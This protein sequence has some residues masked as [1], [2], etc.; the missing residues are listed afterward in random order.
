MEIPYKILILEDDQ[1]LN[2]QHAKLFENHG[3]LVKAVTSAEEAIA[4]LSNGDFDPDVICLDLILTEGGGSLSGYEFFNEL[5]TKW[6]SVAVIVLTAKSENPSEAFDF[7]KRGVHEYIKKSSV[8]EPKQVVAAAMEAIRAQVT[9]QQLV[10]ESTSA[11]F[12]AWQSAQAQVEREI[13]EFLLDARTFLEVDSI[14]SKPDLANAREIIQQ[15]AIAGT[16]LKKKLQAMCNLQRPIQAKRRELKDVILNALKRLQIMGFHLD[17][18]FRIDVEDSIVAIDCSAGDQLFFQ[19]FSAIAERLG[20]GTIHHCNTTAVNTMLTG[21][22]GQQITISD[23]ASSLTK[24]QTDLAVNWFSRATSS[25]TKTRGLFDFE[26][27]ASRLTQATYLARAQ[28]GDLWIENANN[29]G[30]TIELFLPS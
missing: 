20:N 6:P 24:E 2:D 8:T 25:A 22:N 30:L 16:T 23:N 12:L 9:Q 27:F 13:N 11:C 4:V 26:V 5:K 18:R 19:L 1:L 10:E 28:F 21:Q 15:A 7:G 17:N 14:D 29:D 3:F